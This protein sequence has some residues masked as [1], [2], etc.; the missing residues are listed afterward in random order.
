MLRRRVAALHDG[1]SSR[2]GTLCSSAVRERH[3]PDCSLAEGGSGAILP[4]AVLHPLTS[5]ERELIAARI[6]REVTA[7]VTEILHAE[8]QQEQQ[9]K[10]THIKSVA[11]IIVAAVAI[12]ATMIFL[13]VVLAPF[14]LATFFM[15]VLEPVL[16]AFLNPAKAARKICPC[17]CL[18]RLAD[19]IDQAHK[20]TDE[21]WAIGSIS[22]SASEQPADQADDALGRSETSINKKGRR[23]LRRAGCEKTA[24]LIEMLTTK[25]WK[26]F[27]VTGC[28]AIL[29]GIVTGI[30]YFNVR[31]ITDFQWKKYEKSERMQLVLRWFPELGSETEIKIENLLPWLLEGPIFNALDITLSIISQGFLTILFLAFLLAT[32]AATARHEDPNTLPAQIRLTVRRY[33]RIKTGTALFVSLACGTC[34]FLFGVDLFF[35]V[36]CPYF[37][38]LLH[39]ACREHDRDLVPDATCVHGP[40]QDGARHVALVPHTVRCP[41]VERQ[42][43]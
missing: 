1:A 27:A 9:L 5:D 16:F 22:S 7:S 15:F 43:H 25:V 38:S 8:Q 14:L 39:P 11:S 36:R 34:Y 40:H 37:C 30:V 35:S 20:T 4:V 41:P 32:D 19:M 24:M 31:A 23:S 3:Q 6:Q 42:P 33:I 10:Y 2:S 12:G 28:I 21:T 26:L 29:L 13:R 18:G 17:R